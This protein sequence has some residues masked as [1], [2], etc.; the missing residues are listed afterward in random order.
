MH[1]NLLS[2]RAGGRRTIN[3]Y[4]T[5]QQKEETPNMVINHTS[6]LRIGTSKAKR[7]TIASIGNENLTKLQGNPKIDEYK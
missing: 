3:V 4:I 2:D 7:D 1:T 6:Y 5:I